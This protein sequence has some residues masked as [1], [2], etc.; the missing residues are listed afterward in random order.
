MLWLVEQICASGV[1][2]LYEGPVD[3]PAKV[4]ARTLTL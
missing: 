4:C 1:S 3:T 2:R